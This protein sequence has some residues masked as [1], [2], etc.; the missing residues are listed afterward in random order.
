MKDQVQ[1]QAITMKVII[2]PKAEERR[3]AALQFRSVKKQTR[4]HTE[5]PT[6]KLANNSSSADPR[7]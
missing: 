7:P 4:I 6:L 2:Q 5:K 1:Q 3:A